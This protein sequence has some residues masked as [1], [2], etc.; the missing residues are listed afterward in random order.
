MRKPGG[1][2]PSVSRRLYSRATT[3]S[4]ARVVCALEGR[5]RTKVA[6]EHN[7]ATET[8]NNDSGT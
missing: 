1:R 3:R 6:N 7:E 8:G 4:R 2:K 5:V